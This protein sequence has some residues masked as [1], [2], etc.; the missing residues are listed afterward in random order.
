MGWTW[1]WTRRTRCT[2]R[3]AEAVRARVPQVRTL[4]FD[5]ANGFFLNGVRTKIRG[6]ANHQDIA[7]L[8]VAVPDRLQAYRIT[9]LQDFGANGWRTA[10]NQPSAALLDAADR[11]GMLV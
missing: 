9:A 11:L 7:G 3:T 10:H 2:L 1:T 5:G 6:C 4:R 8:G